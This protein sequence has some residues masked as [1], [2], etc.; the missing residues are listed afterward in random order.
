LKKFANITLFLFILSYCLNFKLKIEFVKFF[1]FW[2]IIILLFINSNFLISKRIKIDSLQIFYILFILLSLIGAS[3]SFLLISNPV[4]VLKDIFVLIFIFFLNQ[5]IFSYSDIKSFSHI[6]FLSAL[7]YFTFLFISDF[8]LITIANYRYRG[9]FN[10]PNYLNLLLLLILTSS[11]ISIK[12]TKNKLIKLVAS[13]VIFISIFFSLH[14]LSRS[15]II[16]LLSFFITYFILSIINIIKNPKKF[17]P[18]LQIMLIF[19][20][21]LLI[22]SILPIKN[23]VLNIQTRFTLESLSDLGSAQLRIEEIKAGLS[24]I[25]EKPYLILTG[26][27]VGATNDIVWFKDYFGNTAPFPVRIHNTSVS[28]IVENGLINFIIFLGIIIT[29]FFYIFKYKKFDDKNLYIPILCL[30]IACIILSQ[31]I[32]TVYFLPLWL[33][34]VTYPSLYRTWGIKQHESSSYQ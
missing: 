15:G 29:S 6:L 25:K 26:I 3:V 31:F 30:I 21:S 24:L 18:N 8:D 28:L 10:D 11:F 9:G 1:Y 12:T 32:W 27:G 23:I 34:L 33:S 7:L 14:T 20:A 2:A 5:F 13:C 16:A 19:V 17:V 22:F 4:L